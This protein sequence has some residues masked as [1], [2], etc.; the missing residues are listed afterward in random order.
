[1]K[2]FNYYIAIIATRLTIVALKLFGHNATHLPGRIALAICPKFLKYIDKPETIIGV[3]GTNGKTTVSNIIG[4]VLKKNNI[5]YSNNA[6][7]SNIQEGIVVAM[8][9]SS[10][11]FGRNKIKICVLEID[12]RVAPKIYPY[13]KPTYLVV[14]NLY[15]DSYRRNA[16][17]GY[18]QDILNKN[19]P[20]E[21]TLILNA[22]DVISLELKPNNK[23]V[24]FGINQLDGEVEITDSRIKDIYYCPKCLNKLTYD[25]NRYH[26]LGQVHCLKCGYKTPEADFAVT[27]VDYKKGKVQ[28]K[29]KDE[30]YN[31][32]LIG[33]NITDLY[34]SMAAIA[35]LVTFGIS[36]DSIIKTFNQ[37][38]VVKT[39][40][41]LT[42]VADKKII[43]MMAKDQNPIASSRVCD[44][45]RKYN[46]NENIAYILM[47]E[48]SD[49]GHA[50]ENIAFIYDI[51]FEYLNQPNIKQVI[52]GGMRYLDFIAR[53]KLAGI[54]EE[55]VNGAP[56]EEEAIELVDLELV[57]TIF[58]LYGTKTEPQALKA[59]SYFI[60]KI[61]GGMI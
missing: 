23:R 38:E 27:K 3:T 2:P 57:D 43:V 40:F 34:N 10:H 45:I 29:I 61:K 53:F 36:I 13:I 51:D 30:L 9:Q 8:L 56:S 14:T 12:E 55:V 1:M 39:R 60:N 47:N 48:A 4:D 15:R 24:T 54:K 19:I 33:E 21:T 5:I 50:S 35:L 28:I 59:K 17:V 49:H 41:D 20:D 22:D 6:L 11:F 32:K 46:Q 44:F 37:I 7:G 52:F 25:F 58:I 26:H 16:H 18:I 31:I 42:Q